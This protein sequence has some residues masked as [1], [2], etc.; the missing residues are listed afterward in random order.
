MPE[1]TKDHYASRTF[2]Q[3]VPAGRM[4]TWDNSRISLAQPG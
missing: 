4:L 2:L 3:L 1:A